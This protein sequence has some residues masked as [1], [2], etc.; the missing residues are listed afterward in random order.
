MAVLNNLDR[1]DDPMLER[2]G[3]KVHRKIEFKNQASAL[4]RAKPP[5]ADAEPALDSRALP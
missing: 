2:R 4:K 3:G 5:A 1:A